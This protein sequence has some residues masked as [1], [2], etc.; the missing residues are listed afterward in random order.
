MP[1][2]ILLDFFVKKWN[3]W[4]A[5]SKVL[6]HIMAYLVCGSYYNIILI[7]MKCMQINAVAQNRT[8]VKNQRQSNAEVYDVIVVCLLLNLVHGVLFNLL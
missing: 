3:E 7:V 5:A 1:D 6:D 8:W 2:E 4:L